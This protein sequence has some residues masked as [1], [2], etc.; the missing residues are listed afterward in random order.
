M[1]EVIEERRHDVRTE[2]MQETWK[3]VED[4]EPNKMYRVSYTIT[5]TTTEKSGKPEDKP[6]DDDDDERLFGKHVLLPNSEQV[7]IAII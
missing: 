6:A 2:S 7:N 3:K 4:L 5:T 1:E